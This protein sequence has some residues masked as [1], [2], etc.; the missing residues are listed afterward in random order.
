MKNSFSL[1]PVCWLNHW[2]LEAWDVFFESDKF[3]EEG[4]LEFSFELYDSDFNS[5]TAILK[6]SALTKEVASGL[7]ALVFFYSFGQR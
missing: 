6:K 1:Y 4:V 5:G 2:L 3:L 7:S